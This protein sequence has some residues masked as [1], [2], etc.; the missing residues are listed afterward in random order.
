[1]VKVAAMSD[2]HGELVGLEQ[3]VDL[4]LL[5]GDIVPLKLQEN[6]RKSEKWFKEE[7]IPWAE[8]QPT[9]KVILVAGNHDRYL[10]NNGT[11]KFR[12]LLPRKIIY[13]E[14][15]M[16]LIPDGEKR[17]IAIYGTPLCKPFGNW[18]F[19]PPLEKQ[20]EV[21]DS[22]WQKRFEPSGDT[23]LE[24]KSILLSHDS[25]YGCSDIVL[26]KTCPWYSGEHIGNPELKALIERLKPTINLH[27]H[28]HT[29]NHEAEW[30]GETEV[31][32]VSVLDEQYKVAYKP[33]YFE[34]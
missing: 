5:G 7:F 23:P 16:T 32:C 6:D 12:S 3:E 9:K 29:T 1:M 24:V 31:R 27:G 15:S 14:N 26:D 22:L 19:M 8:G 33:Y 18:Y 25:P 34:I 30:I 20:A 2:L 13:L 11:D 17:V 21:F 28:L 4:L 10:S